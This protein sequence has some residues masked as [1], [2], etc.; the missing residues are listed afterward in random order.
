MEEPVALAYQAGGTGYLQLKNRLLA[1]TL[2]HDANHSHRLFTCH[3][4]RAQDLIN[5][6]AQTQ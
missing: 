3:E 1:S 4:D 5:R 2:A 6:L